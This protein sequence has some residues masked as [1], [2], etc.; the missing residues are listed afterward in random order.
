[1]F[2]KLW[3]LLE[4]TLGTNAEDA[5]WRWQQSWALSGQ[6]LP[7]ALAVLFRSSEDET[8]EKRESGRRIPTVTLRPVPIHVLIKEP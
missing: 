7:V 8:F 2:T 1:M 4:L 3:V 5:L 6:G